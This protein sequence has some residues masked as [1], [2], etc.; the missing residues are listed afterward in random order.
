MRGRQWPREKKKGES[1]QE[2]RQKKRERDQK[3]HFK[4]QSKK[5]KLV[6]AKTNFFKNV[7][8]W[9]CAFDM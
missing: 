5:L 9:A 4:E 8:R 3:K 7:F 6:H 2:K 1:D